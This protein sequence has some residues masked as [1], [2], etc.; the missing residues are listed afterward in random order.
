MPAPERVNEL[1]APSH[2]GGAGEG[3]DIVGDGRI[4]L[5]LIRDKRDRRTRKPPARLVVIGGSGEPGSFRREHLAGK[6]DCQGDA[7]A[8]QHGRRVP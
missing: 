5:T 2:E 1:S 7:C 3:R 4:G 6:Q 8:D